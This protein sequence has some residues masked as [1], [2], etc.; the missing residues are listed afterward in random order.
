MLNTSK[1]CVISCQY[2][3]H[4]S[5][6]FRAV[7]RSMHSAQYANTNL[8]YF[9]NYLTSMEQKYPI[10]DIAFVLQVPTFDPKGYKLN[11]VEEYFE[12]LIEYE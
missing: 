3:A 1:F 12:V 2:V 9:R 10:N 7:R 4:D 11:L 8:E 6:E 5:P